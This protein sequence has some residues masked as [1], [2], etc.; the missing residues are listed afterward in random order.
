MLLFFALIIGLGS[1]YWERKHVNKQHIF[2]FDMIVLSAVDNIILIDRF[3]LAAVDAMIV[4]VMV[5][6][7]YLFRWTI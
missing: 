7:I 6:I 1:G 3:I 4:S 2:L 5:C